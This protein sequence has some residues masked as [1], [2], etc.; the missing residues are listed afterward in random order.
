MKLRPART[1][2]PPDG[3]AEGRLFEKRICG[4]GL[5]RCVTSAGA[6]RRCH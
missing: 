2:C 3:A 4:S 5:R 6:G 1:V